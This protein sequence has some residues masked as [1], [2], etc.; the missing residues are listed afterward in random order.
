[1]TMGEKIL[2]L[3]KAHAW[4]QEELADR[5]G[6]TRQAISRWESDSAK[7]DADNIIQLGKLFGVSSD[8]LL[9]IEEA[10]A[11]TISASPDATRLEG[12][13]ELYRLVVGVTFVTLAVMAFFA[14][15]LI[16]AIDPWGYGDDRNYY[17]GIVGY[18]LAHDLEWLIACMILLLLAGLVMLLWKY[19]KQFCNWLRQTLGKK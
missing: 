10:S 8:Y 6:V 11:A 12:K 16:S 1:M 17:Y 2:K 15:A 9:C 7:P 3:R 4:S 14:L 5:V 13:N 19:V 18:V